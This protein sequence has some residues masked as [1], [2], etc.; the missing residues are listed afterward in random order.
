MMTTRTKTNWIVIKIVLVFIFLIAAN[1]TYAGLLSSSQQKQAE[2]ILDVSG[3]K[4][5]L[6]V[7]V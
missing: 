7:H 1:T 6:I 5:G 2:K 3:V 4:G